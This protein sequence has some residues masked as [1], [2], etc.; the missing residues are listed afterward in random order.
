MSVKKGLLIGINYTG[1]ENQLRGCIND[2]NNLYDFFISNN[3]FDEQDLTFMNDF[4]KSKLYPTKSNILNQLQ[5]LVDF[6]NKNKD[7]Q[8]KLFFSYSGHGIRVRDNNKDE[9]DKYD[10]ALCPIDFSK[11]GVIVDDDIKS[12]FIDLLPSNVELTIM[13]DACHSGTCIDLQ[14]NYD[15]RKD[16]Y[17]I[18][19]PNQR[20]TKC[21]VISISGCL[22]EQ[23]SA[24]ACIDNKYQGAMTAS[25]LNCYK[26]NISVKTLLINMCA[27]LKQ[28]KFTQISQLSS[29][30]LI[31]PEDYFILNY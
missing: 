10:E 6:S 29:G 19:N 30:K 23:T 17:I 22:D 18:K 15:F 12:K 2:T 28:N 26:K 20:L 24:D 4:T 31:K 14:Y 8:V 27:W 25:F 16:N 5:K 7:K 11:S 21:N 3:I 9:L 1:T 13:I